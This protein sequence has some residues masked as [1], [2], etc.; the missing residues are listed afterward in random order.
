MSWAIYARRF[1]N[2]PSKVPRRYSSTL[3]NGGKPFAKMPA[4]RFLFERAEQRKIKS[5]NQW[6]HRAVVNGDPTFCVGQNPLR[7]KNS[8]S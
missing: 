7:V 8:I 6:I 1:D 3:G 5:E 2:R 4:Q